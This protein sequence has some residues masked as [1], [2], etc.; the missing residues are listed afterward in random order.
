MAGGGWGGVSAMW[1]VWR[2]FVTASVTARL[3]MA[4]LGLVAARGSGERG[5]RGE[6]RAEPMEEGGIDEALATGSF[7]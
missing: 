2:V 7:S 6:G 4:L 3:C 1:R 5:G